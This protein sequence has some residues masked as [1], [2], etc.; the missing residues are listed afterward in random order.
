MWNKKIGKISDDLYILGS[1]ENPVYLIGKPGFWTL[2]EGGLAFQKQQILSAL[3][4]I[5]GNL[6]EIGFW[7]ISH[8][9]FDHVGLIPELISELK[10]V[11]IICSTISAQNFK[12][13]KSLQV[14]YNLN[15]E[16]AELNGHSI[17]DE[18]S[19]IARLKNIEPIIVK[20]GDKIEI[21]KNQLFE[22]IETPGHSPCSISLHDPKKRR[23]WIA[24]AFGEIFSEQIWL[25]LH[26]ESSEKYEQSIRKIIQLKPFSIYMGH[27]GCFE[28]KNNEDHAIKNSFKQLLEEQLL[29][30]PL[31][32]VIHEIHEMF[33]PRSAAFLPKYL[34]KKSIEL[35]INQIITE[36]KTEISYAKI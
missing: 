35:I 10:N 3:Q 9:H 23:V 28:I 4:R 33:Y 27:H 17:S 31:E 1:I 34:H 22:V 32:K 15:R 5:V 36:N 11:K 20:E 12:R 13:E 25:P 2:I 26:F 19:Y 29:L 6:N 16:S 30:F 18:E 7:F 21:I 14:I 24:D 8:S